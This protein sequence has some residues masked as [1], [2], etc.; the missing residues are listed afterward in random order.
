MQM[1][2]SHYLYGYQKL[3][4]YWA[5]LDNFLLWRDQFKIGEAT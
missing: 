1:V 5:Y 3:Y 2:E 4:D